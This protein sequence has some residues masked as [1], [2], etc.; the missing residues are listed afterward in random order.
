MSFKGIH[1]KKPADNRSTEPPG[2]HSSNRVRNC[3]AW[4]PA[5]CVIDEV[6]L[7]E[8]VV[9]TN[10]TSHSVESAS[11]LNLRIYLEAERL[12]YVCEFYINFICSVKS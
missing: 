5:T 4:A 3:T 2:D 7:Q 10:V 9:V 6:L 12:A 8:R 1:G 11:R